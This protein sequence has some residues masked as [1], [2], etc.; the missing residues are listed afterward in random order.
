MAAL[1]APFNV[2][3]ARFFTNAIDTKTEGYDLSVGLHAR[4]WP[5]AGTLRLSAGYNATE[6]EIVGAVTTPPQ[7]AG[8]EEVLFDA[9]ERRRIEC[10]QPE[11]NLRLSAD[12]SREQA[13]ANLRGSRYGE[14]CLVDRQVVP[15]I[16]E[17]RV[18]GRPRARL[19]LPRSSPWPSGPRTSSTPSPTATWRRTRTW[20]SSPI[21]AIRR[22]G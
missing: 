6:N 21:R 20:A 13:F 2:T 7:L 18:A 4:A 12:W 22:S 1:L 10:G 5:S 19:P 15:Q 3:G 14:Y 9:I 17:R 11:N 16:F 8:L